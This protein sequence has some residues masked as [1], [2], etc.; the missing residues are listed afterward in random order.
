M[1]SKN[2]CGVEQS[3]R[4]LSVWYLPW[5]DF[6]DAQADSEMQAGILLK[7]ANCQ[8]SIHIAKDPTGVDCTK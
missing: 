4:G 7:V 3:V 2:H 6:I 1:K 5:V 8:L